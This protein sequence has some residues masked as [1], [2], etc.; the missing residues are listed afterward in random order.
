MRSKVIFIALAILINSGCAKT[1]LYDSPSKFFSGIESA[2]IQ[3]SKL[4]LTMIDKALFEEFVVPPDQFDKVKTGNT[5][6]KDVYKNHKILVTG[7][8][9]NC[10]FYVR[11]NY[12]KLLS[13]I[14]L[15]EPILNSD[16]SNEIN[17]KVTC[18]DCNLLG[19]EEQNLFGNAKA[20]VEVKHDFKSIKAFL[21]KIKEQELKAEEVT[22]LKKEKYEQDLLFLKS[23]EAKEALKRDIPSKVNLEEFKA[24]CKLLGF[25]EKT[26]DFGN[27]V[28]QLNEGK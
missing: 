1:Y 15:K 27:C 25:K 3:H 28:L 10:E 9:K 11:N 19:T 23:I 8:N 5:E 16:V 12:Q 13:E 7:F 17:I 26:T 6:W 2:K 14:D 22:R 24:N 20:S 21:V 18:I 4:S